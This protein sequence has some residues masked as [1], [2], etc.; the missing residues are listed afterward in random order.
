VVSVIHVLA[1]EPS[2]N[3]YGGVWRAI[4]TQTKA[5]FSVNRFSRQT[6]SC[7]AVCIDGKGMVKS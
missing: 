4:M 1:Y 6:F 2:P 7:D 5:F 3:T